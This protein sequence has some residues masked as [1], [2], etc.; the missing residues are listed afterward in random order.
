MKR[1]AYEKT[2]N[3]I[4]LSTVGALARMV[5][6]CV[7]AL[8]GVANAVTLTD[9]TPQTTAG[10]DFIFTFSPAGLSDGTDGTFRIHA[11]GDYSTWSPSDEFLTWDIDGFAS[12]TAASAHGTVIREFNFNDVEWEQSFTI[13]GATL[14]T[15][16]S[17]SLINILVDL[18]PGV[19]HRINPTIHF[20]EVEL[21][22]NTMGPPPCSS[23]PDPVNPDPCDG[24]AYVPVDTKL[25]WNASCSAA[26]DLPNG[27][28]ENENFSPWTIIAGPG[29]ELTPWDVSNGGTGYF[30]NA[31]PLEGDFLAQN[32][33]DGTAG[34]FYDIYQEI[35]IPACTSSAV[36]NWS[37]RIQWDM[38]WWGATRPRKYMVSVQPAG[39][40]APLAIL[41]SK[42]LNPGTSGDTGYVSHSIDL[43]SAVPGISGQT[44]RVNFHEDIPETFT[45]PAQFDLDAVSLVCDG[46]AL[47]TTVH[48][49]EI[50]APVADYS[51][52]D[53][54][55][56]G[57]LKAEYDRLRTREAKPRIHAIVEPNS[58]KEETPEVIP[59][60]ISVTSTGGP[61][62]GDYTF[63]DSDEPDGPGF[64]WIEISKTG[65]NL[66]LTDDSYY[67]P[68]NLPFNFDFYGSNYNRLAIGSNGHI[69]FEDEYLGLDNTC[70]PDHARYDADR[71]IAV[72]WDD[73]SP[74]AG[75]ISNVYYKI[76][77]IAP[78]RIL[79]VQWNK[80]SHFRSSDRV[81]VQAQLFE[82]TSDI[83]LLY[84]DPSREAGAR[85]TV[86]I[87]RDPGCGLGYLCNQ[88]TLHEGLAI[89]FTRSSPTEYTWDV[90]FGTDP[91]ALELINCNLTEPMCDPTH[92]R[93]QTLEPET[94]Y[95]WQVVAKNHCSDTNS[96]VRS[97]TTEWCNRLPV[98]CIEGSNC[99]IVECEGSL[100]AKITLD[101]SCSSDV[102]STPGTNDDINDFNWYEVDPCDPGVEYLLGSGEV[103]DIDLPLGK[104]TI[105]LEVIDNAGASD[106]EDITII[107]EDT[108]P[109][110]LQLSVTPTTL[111]PPNHNMVEITPSLTASDI[112]SGAPNVFLKSIV[113]SEGDDIKIEDD[114]SIY[115]RAERNGTGDDRIYTI[116][117]QAI[118][119]SGN[120]T[121][122]S[123][124]VT[125]PHDRR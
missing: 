8:V 79:V 80:I 106:R 115:L 52:A 53:K 17:D 110:E 104:H 68:L 91:N 73:L 90:Y 77:G 2:Q 4:F 16:T 26:C 38:V 108:T 107:T 94:T 97:F 72:Y 85:A 27:G 56:Y 113:M 5:V 44:V 69:Y 78:N 93:C 31:E 12:D 33:F 100:G 11:R 74:I 101:G 75:S 42:M 21:C 13:N 81:T 99:Q 23:P 116:I 82:G 48:R 54:L 112:C 18:S 96:P 22:Y 103:I 19:N 117:Y 1:R 6:L 39:G 55:D 76:A 124:T 118:D 28:F 87:Q 84:A 36:L 70:I 63:I 45:G 114:G 7:F 125:V 66:N 121:E 111:W 15:I 35:V 40:G 41:Y 10:Q 123:A 120:I 30:A 119:D 109:P 67:F 58:A 64:D 47:I 92:N 25:R 24:A 14:R 89:L 29:D 50:S 98:A 88:A 122:Q 3:S 95:Y 60:R 83:L 57:T 65:T 43:L 59:P 62:C 34:L 20:V 9:Y 71:F 102:D 86:G 51:P 49:M 46:R 37:E 61:D 32:G 105:I